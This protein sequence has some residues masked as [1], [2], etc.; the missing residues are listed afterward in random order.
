[1]PPQAPFFKSPKR[2]QAKKNLIFPGNFNAGFTCPQTPLLRFLSV[3]FDHFMS[4]C[5]HM[6]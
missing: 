1:V 3:D 2:K 6:C 4:L 5:V